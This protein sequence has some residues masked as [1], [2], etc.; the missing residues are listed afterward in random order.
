[1]RRV[2][3]LTVVECLIAMTI[4]SATV[5]ATCYALTA[6]QQHVHQGDRISTAVRLGRD[7]LEEVSGRAYRDPG[8]AP[9]FGPEAGETSRA[10]FDDID[11]Y[12]GYAEAAGSVCDAAGTAYPA[13]DQSFSRSV[14][15]RVRTEAV[16]D[17]G[18]SFTGLQVDVKVTAADE[19]SWKFSR[20]IPEPGL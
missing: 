7:L 8:A 10:A 4:L 19:Q 12:S 18:R 14:T 5:L 6:G 2:R 9:L 20:F 11:D 3:G 16:A 17:L 15:V 13:S 1:M